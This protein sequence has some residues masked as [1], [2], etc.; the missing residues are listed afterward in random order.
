MS[1]ELKVIQ[2]IADAVIMGTGT[3][4]L[5]LITTNFNLKLAHFIIKREI[6]NPGMHVSHPYI[7]SIIKKPANQPKK[8]NDPNEKTIIL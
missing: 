3:V 4:F 2:R 7:Y 1:Q 5:I 8:Q 6:K